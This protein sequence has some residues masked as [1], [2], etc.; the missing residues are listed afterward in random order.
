MMTVLT[1]AMVWVLTSSAGAVELVV[2]KVEAAPIVPDHAIWADAPA[3]T[4]KLNPQIIIPPT[5]GGA[6]ASAELKAV[7]DGEWMSIRVEWEDQTMDRAVG[8]DTFRDA[9]AVG[10]PMTDQP[11]SPFMGDAK[12]PVAIW[13]WSANH[14]ANNDGQSQF[15]KMYPKTEGVWYADHDAASS[16]RVHRWRGVEPVEHFVAHGFGTLTPTPDDTLTGN[17]IWF[18]GKWAVVFKRKLASSADPIFGAGM[19]SQM[20]VAVW[21]GGSN[22]VNGRKAVTMAWLPVNLEG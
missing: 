17:G 8:V 20:I 1:A 12:N 2:Q 14:Q 9:A 4:I 18:E 15:A 19:G 13:Q 10:F 5:G 16:V 7:H 6:V 21:D 22:E 11:T 3:T